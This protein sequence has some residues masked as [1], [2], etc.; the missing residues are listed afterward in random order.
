MYKD[1][2]PYSPDLL[3]GLDGQKVGIYVL[4]DDE[5]MRDTL[6]PDGFAVGKIRIT[7]QAHKCQ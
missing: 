1:L 4:N 6:K 3:L 5:V 7:E 2:F